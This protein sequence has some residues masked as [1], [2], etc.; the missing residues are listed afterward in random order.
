MILE[1]E[2]DARGKEIRSDLHS[3]HTRE[4]AAVAVR[5]VQLY[6]VR[7]DRDDQ[8][9]RLE[10]ARMS[11]AYKQQ[12]QSQVSMEVYKGRLGARW[13]VLALSSLMVRT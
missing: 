10:V 13:P 11:S 3:H 7:G 9:Y 12:D 8:R 5:P 1:C 4:H 2:N 6:A